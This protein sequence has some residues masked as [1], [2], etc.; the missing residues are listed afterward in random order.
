MGDG[1]PKA[2][3]PGRRADL[4]PKTGRDAPGAGS[5]E[6]EYKKVRQ[7]SPQFSLG[8]QMRDGEVGHF[9]NPPGS[10]NYFSKDQLTKTHS[11]SWR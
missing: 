9:F 6:P 3:M 11:A 5:Y 1:V 8:K 2:T 10:G 4:R 7:S